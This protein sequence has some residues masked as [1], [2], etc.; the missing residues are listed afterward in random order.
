MPKTKAD[1][2]P[3]LEALDHKATQAAGFYGRVPD[4]TPNVN[5]TF[6]GNFLPTPETDEHLA[7]RAR[8]R[9]R[10]LAA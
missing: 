7:D 10:E 1:K 4:P 6:A 8:A 9:L 5:Y 3:M 2:G